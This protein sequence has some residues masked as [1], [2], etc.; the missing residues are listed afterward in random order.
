MKPNAD[1]PMDYSGYIRTRLVVTEERPDKYARGDYASYW[2]FK[3][4][5]PDGHTGA[6]YQY[7]LKFDPVAPTYQSE[8]V[9]ECHNRNISRIDALAALLEAEKTDI[10]H[11]RAIADTEQAPFSHLVRNGRYSRIPYASIENMLCKERLPEVVKQASRLNGPYS[12]NA[13]K[14]QSKFKKP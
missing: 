1:N 14:I 7:L 9:E 12:K 10:R 3:P 13:K 4:H 6:L 2:L 5:T 8:V 11:N